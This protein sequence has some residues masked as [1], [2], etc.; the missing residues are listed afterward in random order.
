MILQEFAN[1]FAL[2]AEAI[3][4]KEVLEEGYHKIVPQKSKKIEELKNK[5][6]DLEA[7]LSRSSS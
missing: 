1:I 2:F 5:I 7:E 6:T 4:N 3:A